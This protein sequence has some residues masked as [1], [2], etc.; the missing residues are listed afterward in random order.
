MLSNLTLKKL[1]KFI[2]NN[3]TAGLFFV[4]SFINYSCVFMAQ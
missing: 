2:R 4:G 1:E 3:T